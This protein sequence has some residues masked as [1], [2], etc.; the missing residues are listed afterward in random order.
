MT[1]A[2]PPELR[3]T[4]D[5]AERAGDEWGFNCGPGALCALL[6]L[7]PDQVRPHIPDFE[8]KR[9]T[10]PTMMF[11]AL[12]SLGVR[13]ETVGPF[14]GEGRSPEWPRFGLARIQ[15]AG[16]WTKPGVPLRARYRHTHW[17]ASWSHPRLTKLPIAVF[18]VNDC[19]HWTTFESWRD[20]IVPWL[21]KEVEP[22]ANGEWWITHSLEVSSRG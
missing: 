14:N 13:Y 6:G 10:N 16:P 3:F 12:R 1:A 5:D 7:T 2:R 19:R 21:I 4:I 8:S 20:V 11:R 17:V 22:K 18:D 15:W 9:Y